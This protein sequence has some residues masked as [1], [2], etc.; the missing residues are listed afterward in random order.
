LHLRLAEGLVL[1]LVALAGYHE[2]RDPARLVAWV[3]GNLPEL[4]TPQFRPWLALLRGLTNIL[5]CAAVLSVA[6]PAKW[7]AGVRRVA[8]GWLIVVF[9]VTPVL[10]SIELRWRVDE[11]PGANGTYVS[12]THDG[13]VLQTE[14][15]VRALS[16]GE[17]PYA[18]RY[19]TP[20]MSRARDSNPAAWRSIG[21][22]ENPA[23]AHLPYPPGV[24]V[25]VAGPQLAAEAL[26]LAWDTRFL[27]LGCALAL[28]WALG[29]MVPTGSW[30]RMVW[31]ATLCTPFLGE[32]L[33]VGRNDVLVLLPLALFGRALVRGRHGAAAAWLGVALS[34]KQLAV[35][36]L[37]FLFLACP[38]RKRLWPALAIPAAICLPFF[39]WGPA[40]FVS[41]LLWFNV[42]GYPLRWDGFGLSP[43]AFGL[44][45]VAHPA[46]AAPWGWASVVAIVATGAALVVWVR[47]EPTAV[48][49]LV[50]SGLW[51][52]VSL[53]LARF[54]ADNY[55]ATPVV[56]FALALL[57]SRPVVESAP[58]G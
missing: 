17:N 7:G 24:L 39:V 55:V 44:G 31:L 36:A 54:F 2:Q 49:A 27:Y 18:I 48:R 26:D 38:E 12:A 3:F 58:D 16:A 28:A 13:G 25:A 43:I 37:P 51:L 6:S 33:V 46:E 14:M 30:R 9:A 20:P 29:S 52:W 8:A 40:D 21:Y 11:A 50:A 15:A 22:E 47:R 53:F 23:F 56:F 34:M 1:V 35:F 42:S 4:G 10:A 32:F 57:A 41:D 45:L 19:D 5:L